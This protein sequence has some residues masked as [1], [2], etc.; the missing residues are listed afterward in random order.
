MS[1]PLEEVEAPRRTVSVIV[2]VRDEA[3]NVT[4]LVDQLRHAL[5]GRLYEILFVDDRSQDETVDILARLAAND[6]RIRIVRLRAQS[7]KASALSAGFREA[8]GDV[9]ATID[10]DLQDDPAD[11]PGMISRLD[12]GYDLVSGWKVPRRDP[13]RRRLASKVFNWFVR[14]VSG[15]GI[16]DVNCGIKVYTSECIAGVVNDCVGDMHRFLPVF[17]HS[18]GFRVGE[19]IVNHRAR[20]HGKSR[21]GIERY[22]RGALD[23][24]T[25]LLIARFANR[26]MHLLGGLGLKAVLLAGAAF[27][28]YGADHVW[29]GSSASRM[30]AVIGAVLLILGTQAILTG[31]VAE[32]LVHRHQ[33]PIAYTTILALP[34]TQ[35]A[36][37]PSSLVLLPT[38]A[39]EPEPSEV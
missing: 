29:F 16:H 20:V 27:A 33:W 34:N 7:G 25:T 13:F 11:L 26:P 21:Y 15:L 24:V 4:A 6:S 5:V 23:L 18:R 3:P 39:P 36:P 22:A 35:A 31:L 32:A 17:A 38:R 1:A 2:P 37:R 9:I 19:V 30:P 8:R 12:E 10:G 28:W 14:R